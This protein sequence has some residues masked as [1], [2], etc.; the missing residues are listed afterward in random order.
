MAIHSFRRTQVVTA[1]IEKCWSFFSNPRN[2]ALIT[3]PSL[4]FKVLS[5]LGDAIHP[6]MMIEY[7][8]RPLPFLG[9]P[10]TWLTEITGV[11]EPFYFVDEQ[12]VGPYRIWHH[13]HTFR[14]AGNGR[15]EIGDLVHYVLPFSPFSE[16]IHPLLVQPQLRQIFA[17]REKKVAELF[18]E[19]GADEAI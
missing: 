10:I 14:D 13:E 4:D 11:R 9:I 7:R 17:F 15:T 19:S 1:S 6:G 2:L 12:R 5:E 3:P 8:V 18:G 16:I